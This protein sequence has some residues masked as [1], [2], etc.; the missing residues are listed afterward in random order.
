MKE[1]LSGWEWADGCIATNRIAAEGRRVGL[2]L[3]GGAGWRLRQRMALHRRGRERD[4]PEIVP[5]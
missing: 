5:C 2:L 3:P 1:L 4:D